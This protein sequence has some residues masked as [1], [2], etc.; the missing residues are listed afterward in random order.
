MAAFEE[1]LTTEAALREII[2]SPGRRAANKQIDHLDHHCREFIAHS[3]FA[4]VATT[5]PD[6]TGDASPKGGP[7][8]FVRVLDDHR[9]AMGELPGNGR[10]DGYRNLLANP[11]VGLIF[12]V[13]GLGETLRVNGRGYV[14]TDP[15]VLEACALDGRRPVLALGVEV[16]EAFIHCAKA[17]RRANL[18]EPD[19]WPDRAGMPTVACML[20]EHAGIEGDPD[21]SRTAVA[22]EEAYATSLW[23]A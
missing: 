1:V 12:L 8:G 7:P 5:N 13:P 9:L 17:L 4:V 15:A 3:P 19:R 22:L 6:G 2:R 11:A 21:G 14:V 10:V 18:W 20:A 23:N 16:A